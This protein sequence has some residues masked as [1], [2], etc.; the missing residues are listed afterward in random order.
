MVRIW[1]KTI[2]QKNQAF[3]KLRLS[4]LYTSIGGPSFRHPC[5]ND[6][7]ELGNEQKLDIENAVLD[8]N[9]NIHRANPLVVIADFVGHFVAYAQ[10][11]EVRI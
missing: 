1:S 3:L 8:H 10:F 11:V 7:Q 9:F 2:Y 6:E 4:S 5:R